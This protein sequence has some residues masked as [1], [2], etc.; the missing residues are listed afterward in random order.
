[1]VQRF[2]LENSPVLGTKYNQNQMDDVVI[3]SYSNNIIHNNQVSKEY[4]KS[5]G[6]K[7]PNMPKDYINIQLSPQVKEF[8][9][10]IQI[11]KKAKIDNSFLETSS[12]FREC[13]RTIQPPRFG[14][15]GPDHIYESQNLSLMD[16]NKIIAGDLQRN[17][18]HSFDGKLNAQEISAIEPL[19]ISNIEKTR[20]TIGNVSFDQI[21]AKDLKN[22]LYISGG[23]YGYDGRLA[24]AI[25]DQNFDQSYDIEKKKDHV[26]QL[27]ENNSIYLQ[28]EVKEEENL[29]KNTL[30]DFE[31]ISDRKFDL[32]LQILP[33]TNR[34][35]EIMNMP[36]IESHSF[37][38]NETTHITRLNDT[39][40]QVIT[41]NNIDSTYFLK[42]LPSS[43]LY[44]SLRE[45]SS[46]KDF[47]QSCDQ[48]QLSDNFH[49]QN[50][51]NVQGIQSIQVN[52]KIDG[53]LQ[54]DLKQS[55]YKISKDYSSNHSHED[56]TPINTTVTQKNNNNEYNTTINTSL[57]EK[58]LIN[59]QK[60][61]TNIIDLNMN[62]ASLTDIRVNSFDLTSDIKEL[63][64]SNFSINL[65]LRRNS[66]VKTF[67]SSSLCPNK[68]VNKSIHKN[69]L[70]K[71]SNP[72]TN[73]RNSSQEEI[74]LQ[75]E[76]FNMSEDQSINE[77]HSEQEQ[78]NL[79]NI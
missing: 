5:A 41:N 74:K 73:D 27:L 19:N 58:V 20:L 17:L 52:Q 35:H 66:L 4:L 53:N 50:F 71:S 33:K 31:T 61:I 14:L 12:F 28:E 11:D 8:L 25:G 78:Q 18:F 67:S 72:K 68:K 30:I 36:N 69:N 37:H 13:S 6:K 60:F 59:E 65:S 3:S 21:K 34:S 43:S 55:V 49:T 64:N 42:N 54:V 62:N 76:S 16:G 44:I 63:K 57:T 77:S 45:Q 46:T 70:E 23:T 15:C 79:G 51:D 7:D 1:M 39:T 2:S 22:D 48:I 75:A 38:Q 32:P 56:I 10:D 40:N 9:Q 47:R 29:S 26:F 24:V